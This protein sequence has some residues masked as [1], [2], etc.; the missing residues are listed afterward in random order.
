M[1]LAAI[2][3]RDG[4]ARIARND[5]HRRGDESRPSSNVARSAPP[6]RA[7]AVTPSSA[8]PAVQRTRTERRSGRSPRFESGARCRVRSH[9]VTLNALRSF[10]RRCSIC[11]QT[12]GEMRSPAGGAGTAAV[13]LHVMLECNVEIG[14]NVAG[15]GSALRPTYDPSG[16]Q[17]EPQS[18]PTP[19]APRHWRC[20]GRSSSHPC[21]SIRGP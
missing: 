7:H 19:T 4:L 16:S 20:C 13:V 18:A 21:A 15:S 17:N 1:P 5:E 14:E 2:S 12:D 6:N 8:V 3:L 11:A 10:A 9:P